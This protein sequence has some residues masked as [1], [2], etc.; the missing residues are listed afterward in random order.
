MT[1]I[2]PMKELAIFAA[3]KSTKGNI[4][5]FTKTLIANYFQAMDIIEDY[6]KQSKKDQRQAKIAAK[7]EA[8]KADKL[9]K[10][11]AK[12]SKKAKLLSEQEELPVAH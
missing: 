8:R 1:K 2:D 11:I 5:E 12:S 6:T 4:D 3:K 9:K 7:L 10:Q